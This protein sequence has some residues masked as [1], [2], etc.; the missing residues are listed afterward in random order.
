MLIALLL[1]ATP[2]VTAQTFLADLREARAPQVAA[3]LGE[4]MKAAISAAAL[5]DA[6]KQATEPLGA[7]VSLE[8][9]QTV[10]QGGLAVFIHTAKFAKGALQ[11]TTA[12]DPAKSTIEGFFIK[13]LDPTPPAPAPKASYV[14]PDAFGSFEVKVG[15]APFE[16]GGTLTVPKGKGPFPAVVLVHGSGPQDR[17][18][19]I[20]ANTVFKDLAEGLSSKGVVVL[21]YDKRTFVYGKQYAGKDI[22]FDEEVIDDAKAAVTLLHARPDVKHVYVV[23]HSLGALLAPAVAAKSAGQVTGVVLLAP[24]S[25]KPWDILAQQTKYLGAPPE[26]VAEL[27]AAFA[28]L[29]L[30][31]KPQGLILNVPAAYWRA[32]ADFDGPAIAKGLKLPLLVMHGARDYQVIDEDLAGWKKGLAGVKQVEFVELPKLNHLF[33]AGEGA[34]SPKEYEVP[35]HVDAA[36]LERLVKFVR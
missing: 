22:T 15:A 26:K 30:G 13:P 3:V 10:Q 24:S 28:E 4:K 1:A 6:W 19:T 14:T 8:Q 20:R 17:D 25:R 2:D 21:R 27:E 23:G 12:V 18:E 9:T 11:T 29:R 16:L 35:S 7:F 31:G 33:I 36:V 5:I 32:W 34:P